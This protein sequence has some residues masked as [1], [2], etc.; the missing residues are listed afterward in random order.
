MDE[1]LFARL[2]DA[3]ATYDLSLQYRMNDP[4]MQLSNEL[5]Y[6]GALHCGDPKVA[7]ACINPRNVAAVSYDEL[8]FYCLLHLN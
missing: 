7:E 4:I 2:D 8:K 1:S 5:V 6:G 3:G